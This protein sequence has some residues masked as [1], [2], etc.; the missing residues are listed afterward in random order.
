[1]IIH[2]RATADRNNDD[3]DDAKRLASGSFG[4]IREI[5][6]LLGRSAMIDE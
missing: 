2:P 4:L 6:V 5:V 1:M 3:A